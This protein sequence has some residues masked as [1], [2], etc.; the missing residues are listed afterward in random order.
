M[1]N[2]I[3]QIFSC[4]LFVA[5]AVQFSEF[6]STAYA[7]DLHFSGGGGIRHNDADGHIK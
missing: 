4:I 3:M 6:S 2:A 5:V 1:I 7:A